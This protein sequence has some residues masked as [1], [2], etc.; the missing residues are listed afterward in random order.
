MPIFSDRQKYTITN[1][2][3]VAVLDIKH[4]DKNDESI[5][6]CF[7]QN[8]YGKAACSAVLHVVGMGDSKGILSDSG[9]G[10]C[11]PVN[12]TT[13]IMGMQIIH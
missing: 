10:K 11:I 4:V 6:T 1:D 8:F 12:F 5:I 13:D 9:G 7:A 2:H 3:G